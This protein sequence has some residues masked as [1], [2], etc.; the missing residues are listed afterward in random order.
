MS[1]FESKL[2]ELAWLSLTKP[3]S[4]KIEDAKLTANEAGKV[5]HMSNGRL[6]FQDPEEAERRAIRH[7][8]NTVITPTTQTPAILFEALQQCWLSSGPARKGNLT[9]AALAGLHNSGQIDALQ[10]AITAVQGGGH[11]FAISRV[12]SES[13]PLFDHIDVPNLLIL[14][15]LVGAQGFL[16]HAAGE[17]MASHP[18]S[19]DEVVRGCAATPSEA[20]APLLRTALI[21]AVAYDRSLWLAR[22]HD[23]VNNENEHTS[24]SAV[25]ALGWLDWTQADPQDISKAIEVVRTGLRSDNER[26]VVVSTEAGLNLVT[27]ATDRHALISEITALDKPYV[28]QQIGDH[29]AYRGEHLKSQHWYTEQIALLAS[30]SGQSPGS[31]HGID[32]ILTE[33]YK[34]QQKAASLD[35]LDIWMGANSDSSLSLPE[36]FPQFFEALALEDEVLGALLAKWLTQPDPDAQRMTRS[37][38]DTL[39]LRER[40]SLRFPTSTLDAMSLSGLLHLVR[41]VLGNVI[42]EEQRISLLWSLTRTESA[43]TRTYPLIRDAM[44]NFVG[45]DYPTATRDY[46]DA[47]IAKEQLTPTAKLA[48]EILDAMGTYYNA[49]DAL[50]TIEELRPL[51]E[52]SHRFAKEHHRK[53]NAAF[54]EASKKSIWRQIATTIH[55]KAGRSSFSMRDGRVG[56]KMH[57]SSASHSMAL[58]RSESIDKVG[59]DLQRKHFILGVESDEE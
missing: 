21:Q 44:V 50:P 14:V 57:M 25:E 22:I 29:L 28:V 54:E 59:S 9:G 12:V 16:Q 34:S 41:R 45:Y 15:G 55:L 7:L 30:K 46:L 5:C 37:I 53:M 6:T 19:I 52:H 18:A 2:D 58:P 42:R 8:Q 1:E 31:Y 17:W 26:R 35:W 13:L 33:M 23:L 49:L 36:E 43:E 24:L 47:I 48:Q 56:E 32:H 20:L 51:S 38:I 39:G 40:G 3:D 11:A 10:M 4:A 27:T